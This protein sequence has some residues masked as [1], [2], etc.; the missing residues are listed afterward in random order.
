MK[1]LVNTCILVA[2]WLSI[3]CQ[4]SAESETNDDSQLSEALTYQHVNPRRA[5]QLLEQAIATASQQDQFIGEPEAIKRLWLIY[6]LYKVGLE[7]QAEKYG[8]QL[9]SREATSKAKPWVNLA[10]AVVELNK[11]EIN[12]AQ[13]LLDKVAL[14]L[15]EHNNERLTM[16]HSLSLGAIESRGS[17]YEKA[18]IH[19]NQAEKLASE[20]KNALVLMNVLSQQIN[21]EYYMRQYSKALE[22]NENFLKQSKRLQDEF[23]EVFAYSNAMNIHYMLALQAEQAAAEIIDESL[24]KTKLQ[25]AERHRKLS[26]KYRDL[27]LTVGEEVGA[28]KPRMR[29][30]IQLQ[31]QFIRD[32]NLDQV[33]A[34][35]AKTI[36][37]ADEQGVLYEKGVSLN[38]LAIA[39]RTAGLYQEALE[40]LAEADKIYQTIQHPQS[41]LWALEDYSI[42]YELAGDHENALNYYKQY[43]QKSLELIQETNSERVL[44]LQEI[45]EAEKSRQEIQRLNQDNTLKA[46]ELKAQQL[47]T[48]VF[49]G[50]GLF[51]ATVLIFFY[52]RNKLITEKNT[53]LDQLNA[54]L[55]EQAF[56]DPLTKLQNRRFLKEIQ[57]RME[58][59]VIRR[60]HKDSDSKQK[61]GIVILDIDH[62]KNINDQFG[63]DIGDTVIK[64]FADILTTNLREGDIAIR[65]G[66]EEFF[67]TLFDTDIL[68]VETFCQR[69][70]QTCNQETMKIDEHE[71]KVTASLGYALFPLISDNP[72]WFNWNEAMRLIDTYLYAAKKEGRNCS[73]TVDLEALD[74]SLRSKQVILSADFIDKISTTSSYKKLTIRY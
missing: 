25:T 63:H 45:F 2:L 31:N 65:W 52:S 7:Q 47:Q 62:F 4:V 50:L 68:G 27:V 15:D 28:F 20:F 33:K 42:I 55:Q 13:R 10:E 66:G 69:I 23:Y 40:A 51:L 72:D 29:A 36:E 37:I 5:I 38:N 73:V 17:Q 49:V 60:V 11:Q 59:S 35:V 53:K 46:S 56:R 34:L 61:L 18:L 19:L 57:P 67:V 12:N 70:M 22:H 41:M 44:E 14:Y 48:A 64:N 39:Y 54:K 6:L 71:I 24:Q 30:L 74:D 3:S 58:S 9:S 26:E 16:W 21:I 32:E 1:T 8:V 43:H